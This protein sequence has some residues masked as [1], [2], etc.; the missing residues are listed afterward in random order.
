MFKEYLFLCGEIFSGKSV[1]RSLL[2][3]H[4]KTITIKGKTIDIGGGK[5]SDYISFMKRERGVSFE[6]FDI[7][8][9]QKE[10]NFETDA[11]PSANDNYDT[12]IFLNVLE[13]IFNHQHIA[14]EVV[15]IVKPG[16]QL[17]GFV[18][19]LMWYHPDHR[20]YFRY[21]H[22][23]LQ[24]ILEKTGVK[25]IN[26][27]PVVRGPFLASLHIRLYSFPKIIRPIL[28][29][30]SYLLDKLYVKLKVKKGEN[31]RYIIGYIFLLEK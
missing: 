12:V 9:G 11:L 10:V 27:Q 4:L 8:A 30:F 25:N 1:L 19:F 13:H 28:F 16:G 14:N 7:K 26:I 17:I 20:D 6:T 24:I 2:N 21:T 3:F 18:P 31:S 23:A 22:E 5:N 15:R 29:T